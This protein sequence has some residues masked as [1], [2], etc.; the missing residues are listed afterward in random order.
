M[1]FKFECVKINCKNG[2]PL[3]FFILYFAISD[4]LTF[5]LVYCYNKLKPVMKCDHF[6]QMMI[7]IELIYSKYL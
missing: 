6:F 5:V 4:I 7:K 1:K 3:L 2:F